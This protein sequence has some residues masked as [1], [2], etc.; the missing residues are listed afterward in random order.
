VERRRVCTQNAGAI[1]KMAGS[2]LKMDC[3]TRCLR[4]PTLMGC[5]M[6]PQMAEFGLNLV[7]WHGLCWVLG[8]TSA[9]GQRLLW[10]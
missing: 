9:G 6:R 8:T 2:I 10:E 3:R 7:G 1:L 4:G 5:A